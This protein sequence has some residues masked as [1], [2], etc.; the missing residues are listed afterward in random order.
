[1]HGTPRLRIKV[2]REI[3]GFS[4]R[5]PKARIINTAR[6]PKAEAIWGILCLVKLKYVELKLPQRDPN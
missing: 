3:P 4:H 6:T 5:R 2:V 1:M